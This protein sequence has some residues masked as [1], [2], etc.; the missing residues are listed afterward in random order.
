MS[1]GTVEK[2][3]E[4]LGIADVI[5][6]YL[7]LEKAGANMKAR[8]PFHNEKTPSFFVS[9]ARNSYYCFG[10]GAKGDI[11]TFVEEFE[12]LDFMGALR[13]LA[14]R[15]GVPLVAENP[16]EKS[17]R[18]ELYAVMKESARFF[19]ENLAKNKEALLYLKKRGLKIET[20]RDW[21]IGFAPLD[22]RVLLTHLKNKGY[23]ESIMEKAGLVKKAEAV[24]EDKS[25]PRLYDR[26]RGRVMF[27]IFDSSG[28]VIAFSGRILVDDEKSAKYLNSPDTPLFNK[29]EV[30]YGYHIAK[31]E[32]KK[33]DFSILVEGQMDLL[34]SQQ[35][36]L[37]NTVAVSGTA[38]TVQHLS[39]LGRLSKKVVLAF[40][41]DSAGFNAAEKSARV[42]LSLGM[43]VKMVEIKGGKDP[44][45]LI[46]SNPEDWKVAVGEAIHIIDF[47][48]HKV[49]KDEK[50]ERQ[51]GKEIRKKV[52]PYVI[53]LESRIEQSHFVRKISE[54]TNIPEDAI[55]EDLKK[56]ESIKEENALEIKT[57][58]KKEESQRKNK[59]EEKL[60]GLILWQE[61]LPKSLIDTVKVRKEFE[62][63]AGKDELMRFEESKEEK[64]RVI[65]EAETFFSGASNLEKDLKELIFN[66]KEDYLKAEFAKTMN[67]LVQAERDKSG[68]KA[69]ELLKKCKDIGEE[70]TKLRKAFQ[71]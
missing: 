28:R 46:L 32:I 53:S 6:S 5:G 71:S 35:A 9:V 54:A 67:E 64:N 23:S 52:L 42:A 18:D 61:G 58:K 51:L 29:S 16:K 45:D 63:I 40:D 49:V 15:A 26:F 44:A 39:M 14:Q 48:L 21:Q 10:C 30:L 33:Q 69:E 8:C 31:W 12:G 37:T 47:L 22:W 57:E 56:T 17:E 7:K 20:V 65:F 50:D 41:A 34:M 4:R 70:L 66:L 24:G 2:I 38:L 11:F 62:K 13:V 36:G 43:E 25:A 3:K 68:S 19:Q 60:V 1:S 59:I 55:W 27:P